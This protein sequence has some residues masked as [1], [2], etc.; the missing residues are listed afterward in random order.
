MNAGLVS[1]SLIVGLIAASI[2]LA[3]PILLTAIGEIFTERSGILNLGLE[4][5]MLMG[6]L[7]GFLVAYLSNSLWLG[8]LASMLTGMLFGLLMGFMSITARV[9]QVVAGIGITIL[10]GGLS[11]LLFRLYFGLRTEPPTLSPFPALRIPLLSEIPFLGPTLFN[12]NVMVYLSMALV[13][14]SWIILYR[15]NFGLAVRA[16]GEKPKAADTR[17][18]S[19]AFI[20]YASVIIGGALA[21]IGGAFLPLGYLGIFWTHMTAGRGFIAVAV[22]IFSRWDPARALLGALIFGGAM[23][24]QLA[25]QTLNVPIPSE[26]LQMLPFV[27]TILALISISRRAEFP[28]AFTIPYKRGE[29]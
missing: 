10:G 22:V 4:G 16:V 8:I 21:G 19:I 1:M 9:N 7:S 12:H 13:P 6:A 24:L 23:A 26:W 18:I 27:I 25:L 2:R 5:I 3:A 11:T 14:V 28:G 20:R 17:G 29:F 15:T